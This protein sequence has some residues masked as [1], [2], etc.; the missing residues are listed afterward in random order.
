MIGFNN[1]D[2][3]ESA[4]LIEKFARE[5]L[6]KRGDASGRTPISLKLYPRSRPSRSARRKRRV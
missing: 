5:L 6:K 2:A 3:A 1:A 4:K